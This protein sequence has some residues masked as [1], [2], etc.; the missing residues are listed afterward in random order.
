MLLANTADAAEYKVIEVLRGG[1]IAGQVS[2][3]GPLPANAIEKVKITKNPEICGTGEAE[4]VWVDVKDGNL[5]G[6][7]VFLDRIKA[8]KKWPQLKGKPVI[9]QKDCRFSPP[10]Q[11]I[12]PGPVIVRNSDADVLHN[13][14]AREIIGVG[15]KRIVHRTLFN[16]GQPKV[17]ELDLQMKPRRAPYIA[18]NCETHAAMFAFILAPKNPY[19]VIVDAEGRY[20]IGD[21]PPGEYSVKAWHPKLGIRRS[22]ITVKKGEKAALDFIFG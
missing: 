1:S 8:G 18:L 15:K 10:T 22:K 17:G 6:V 9:D 19:A 11:I 3:K 2:F 21:I 13:V 20:Q 16:I 12:Q 4:L 5:R 14:N 7:F